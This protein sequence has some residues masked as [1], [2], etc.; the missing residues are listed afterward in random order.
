M[1]DAKTKA[2]R[3][4]Q[5]VDRE[6]HDAIISRENQIAKIPIVIYVSSSVPSSREFTPQLLELS[7]RK[8]FVDAG[9]QFYEM[10]MTNK[11]TPMIKFG[12][13]NC[14]LVLLFRG[15]WCETLLGIRSIDAVEQ[16]VQRMVDRA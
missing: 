5:I 10:E 16:A 2:D 12:P 7:Q 11:T 1:G 9:V 3:L 6:S 4:P 14:P 13:Q 8:D 15:E